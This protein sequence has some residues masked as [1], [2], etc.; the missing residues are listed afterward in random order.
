VWV[1]D[2]INFAIINYNF[3][4]LFYGNG[5]LVTLIDKTDSLATFRLDDGGDSF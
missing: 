2:D 4:L 3:K 1:V 5:K